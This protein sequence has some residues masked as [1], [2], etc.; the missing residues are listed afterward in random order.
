[1]IGTEGSRGGER[2]FG[3]ENVHLRMEESLVEEEPS[4]APE[5]VEGRQGSAE[6]GMM[7][8]GAIKR[9]RRT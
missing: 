7:T 4:V 3:G 5:R 2:T 9:G 1:M 6:D 8:E